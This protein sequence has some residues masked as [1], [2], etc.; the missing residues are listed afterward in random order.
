MGRQL[1]T[2]KSKTINLNMG[3]AALRAVDDQG[4]GFNVHNSLFTVA[5]IQ[6]TD[7]QSA[8]GDRNRDTYCLDH[9]QVPPGLDCSE[10]ALERPRNVAQLQFEAQGQ[11]CSRMFVYQADPQK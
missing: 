8:R 1:R 3:D 10:P 4:C 7:D 9:I 5:H 11:H 2:L 6:E